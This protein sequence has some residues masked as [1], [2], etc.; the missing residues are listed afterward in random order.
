M[1]QSTNLAK[2]SSYRSSPRTKQTKKGFGL[3]LGSPLRNHWLDRETK[4]V[5]LDLE[6]G[7]QGIRVRL[8][9]GFWN[10]CAEFMADEVYDWILAQGLAMPWPYGQPHHFMMERLS[11]THFYVRRLTAVRVEGGLVK[12]VA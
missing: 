5:L 2:V 10:K 7:P 11:A 8:R 4:E 1:T 9:G 3:K 12:A 6:G